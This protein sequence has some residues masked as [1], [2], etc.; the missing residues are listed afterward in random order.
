MKTTF[1]QDCYASTF[2]PVNIVK[3]F[4]T[5]SRPISIVW[6]GPVNIV[7]RSLPPTGLFLLFGLDQWILWGVH[8]LQQAYFYCLGW[9]CEY[10]EGVHYLQQVYF[11]CLGWTSKYCEAF[12]TSN[13]PISIVWAGPVNI[14]RRSLPPTSLFLLFGLDL[15]ILWRRSLPPAGLF[16]LFGLER[17]QVLGRLLSCRGHLI[18]AGIAV[19]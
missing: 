15:W 7:R 18:I 14:V 6:V 1:Q 11:Y 16:L 19:N 3:A 17:A 12:I 5:S 9:N 13:R 10:C 4:I 8:Y 2:G